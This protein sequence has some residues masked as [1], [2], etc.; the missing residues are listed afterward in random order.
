M[1]IMTHAY[2]PAAELPTTVHAQPTK[3]ALSRQTLAALGVVFGDIGTSPLYAFR[4]CFTAPS[5]VTNVE[6]NIFGILSL[7][8]WSLIMVISVKYVAVMLKADNRGEGGVLALSTLL[9]GATRNW[10][11]WTPIAVMGLLG[12]ALFFGDGILTPAI[13][14]LS[15]VE[16]LTVAAPQLHTV[17]IPVTLVVLLV[18]FSAQKKGTGAVGR[19]FGPV[20]IVWFLA[21]GLLGLLKI[22][23]VPRVMQAINPL[24]AIEFF[25]NNG[26]QGFVTLSAVFLAVTGGEALYAD[27]GHFGRLPIRNAWMQLVLPALTLNYFGQGALLL[28]D[29]A[30]V[31]NPFYLLAPAWALPPLIALA[32]A[33][34]IIASQAVISGVFSVTTQALNL[35]YLPRIRVRH[36]SETEIGQVYVPSMNWVLFA[37]TVLLVLVFRSSD[38]LA[39]AYGIAVSSTMLMAG[40]MVCMLAYMTRQVRRPVTLALLLT[41]SLID[42]AFFLSNALKFFDGGWFPVTVAIALY[43]LMATWHEGRRTLN[44]TIAREQV[45]PHDFLHALTTRPPQQVPGTAVYLVSEASVIPRSMTQSVRFYGAMHQRNILLTF[46][47]ADAPR[48]LPDER[49]SVE[50]LA[51][52]LYRVLARYGFME[53]PNVIAALKGA[54]ELGLEYQ[55]NDTV[56]IVGHDAAI[57]TAHKGMA[58]WRKRL[59]AFMSRNSQMASMHYGVPMHRV[60]EIGSQTAL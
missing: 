60:I 12:A 5:G 40:L 30:A 29:P 48:L 25:A 17:V 37:G 38:A 20:M 49:V 56:Y 2:E 26:W 28:I 42:L 39:G 41:I 9:A 31:T 3:R 16:G 35:G 47:S 15:A 36:S 27:M 43:T 54:N 32:T 51:P 52:G 33:A 1:T 13:S 23:Q 22:L 7:I 8:F 50:T 4:Q 57:V 21:I 53:Q 58:M 59:F 45:S 19:V 10:K 11:L 14:V 6:S 18:L 44:W 34:T 55:P 46:V 24:Y